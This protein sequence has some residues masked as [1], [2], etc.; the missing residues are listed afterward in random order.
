MS[1]AVRKLKESLTEENVNFILQFNDTTAM[2][3][4]QEESRPMFGLDIEYKPLRAAK[5]ENLV[6]RDMSLIDE[7]RPFEEFSMSYEN[8]KTTVFD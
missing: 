8:H 1:Q 6:L 7:P 5:P 4:G 2:S 3:N